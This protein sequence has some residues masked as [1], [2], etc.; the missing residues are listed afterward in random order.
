[1]AGWMTLKSSRHQVAISGI[2]SDAQ[3]GQVIPGAEV[4]LSKGSAEFSRWLNLKAIQHGESLNRQG[5]VVL[6]SNL[7]LVRDQTGLY[8][9][10]QTA[11]EGHFYFIDLPSG[12]YDLFV[13]LPGA[14]TR[15]GT[16]LIENVNVTERDGN[17]EHAIADTTLPSTGIKGRI[18]DADG[19]PIVMAKLQVEGSS[20]VAFSDRN[21]NY[22]I[23]A[24]EVWQQSD[25]SSDAPRP[26]ITVSAQGYQ[27]TT[28]GI[29]L[30]LGEVK[31]FDIPLTRK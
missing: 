19:Q 21:G 11:L 20:L 2:V 9:A 28:A 16:R 14:G 22:L 23:T 1:M 10:T 4:R 31:S 3:V 15:Y 17:I 26:L 6:N 25:R 30:G 27:N 24:L 7:S 18:V 5:S 12:I 29:W 13:S 8:L